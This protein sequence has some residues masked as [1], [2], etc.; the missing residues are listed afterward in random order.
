MS[1]SLDL[2]PEEAEK[3]RK[4]R[5]DNDTKLPAEIKALKAEVE[6][7]VKCSLLVES[8]KLYSYK[9][10]TFGYGNVHS[11]IAVVGLAPGR[12][13]CGATGIPFAR[14]RSGLLYA[15]ALAAM[16]LT[17]E[18]V[19]TTNGV[20]CTPKDNREPSEFEISNC[21][22]FLDRELRLVKPIAVIAV[23]R[24]AEK[25]VK[26]LF[27]HRFIIR[28]IYHPAYYL[29]I[30]SPDKFIAEFKKTYTDLMKLVDRVELSRAP[31]SLDVF[32]FQV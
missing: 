11:K 20:K 24:V 28:N 31:P 23:G 27:G 17:T 5:E 15:K 6:S 14:D 10:P 13:G 18:D 4:L 16:N 21:S 30:N 26:T 12:F 8:R 29:R 3:Y 22:G 19:W 9:L 1:L 25:T 2:S 7:C 32:G